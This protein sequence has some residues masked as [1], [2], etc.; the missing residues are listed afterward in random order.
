MAD[1]QQNERDI[2]GAEEKNDITP[3]ELTGEPL[4]SDADTSRREVEEARAAAA[5]FKDQ[6]LRKAAEF[7]NYRRRT[8]ADFANIIKNANENLMLSLIPVLDDFERS[9]K[10]GKES[11]DYDGFYKGVSLI[12]GKLTKILEAQGLTP[13]ES[14]GKPFDVDLHDA[15]LQVPRNDVPAHTVIEEVERG[16]MLHKKVLRHAKVVVSTTPPEDTDGKA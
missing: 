5:G 11:T 9:L 6:L 4:E 3:A 7:E 15:L 1:T 14:A 12:Q 16:Y 13:F 2:S 10:A 8:E